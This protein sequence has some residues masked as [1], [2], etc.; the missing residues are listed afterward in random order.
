MQVY[1]LCT[2]SV[3]SNSDPE[4]FL[5]PSTVTNTRY[6]SNSSGTIPVS[7]STTTRQRAE[8]SYGNGDELHPESLKCVVIIKY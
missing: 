2:R 3:N 6:T 1:A 8:F 7:G 4:M 5:I